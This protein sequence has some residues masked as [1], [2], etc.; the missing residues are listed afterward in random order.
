MSSSPYH[1]RQ[2]LNQRKKLI[3]HSLDSKSLAAD[4]NPLSLECASLDSIRTDLSI[5]SKDVII[6][7]QWI[8]LGRIGEGSFGEVFEAEDID[9]GR[10]YA[11]K[12]EPIKMRNRQIKHE[13]IIYDVLAGGPGIPQCHWHGQHD[14]FDCIVMDL[15][16]PNVNQLKEFLKKLPI[17][18]VVDFGC[19]MVTIVEHIH[20]RGLV[21][22]DIK[23]DN[24]LFSS[25]CFLPEPEMIE[26]TD[27]HG[28][29]M[30][31]Y[32]YPTCEEIFQKW[33][34]SHPKLYLVDFGLTTWWKNPATEK[35]Y[36]ETKK[37]YRNR[38]GTA[39]YASLHV[40][41]GK[42]HARRDDI[43]SIG[44]LLLDLVLGTLPWTGIQARNSRAGWDKMKQIKEDTFMDDLCAGL[45]Q[46]LLKFIEYARKI[47]FAEEPNYELLRQ[48][49]QGSIQ[50]GPYSDIIK[51]PFGGH[52]ESK[53]MQENDKS[54]VID[55]QRIT[56]NLHRQQEQQQYRYSP[57][58]QH[59]HRKPSYSHR[60]YNEDPGVFQMDDLAQAVND[61]KPN[62]PA[63]KRFSN[64]YRRTSRDFGKT[65]ETGYKFGTRSRKKPKQV[66]WNTH[67]HDNEPW[68]PT[69]DWTAPSEK[70][71]NNEKRVSWG[72]NN[73][74]AACDNK[75]QM[76][77]GNDQ[78]EEEGSWAATVNKPWE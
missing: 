38:A 10:K 13:N 56:N 35:P 37:D 52:T 64:S 59:R 15:L 34:V 55:K 72:E 71:E 69:I 50:G 53:W 1:I 54:V 73:P 28:M 40:H 43:E 68:A 3:S 77:W 21:Y 19:Q 25:Q 16:G 31:K 63:Q 14:E 46:G 17:E 60:G 11:V 76:N 36:P 30:I 29:S 26:S 24:F 62:T 57:Q 6:A 18:V 32:R 70:V 20:K 9:T 27:D 5:G 48:L 51:S 2:P 78:I 45:P 74:A 33:N 41:R 47:K 75:D 61:I 58:Q 12:R 65:C 44:Y 23:P 49:L 42:P 39:R 22:R 8:V 66:G 7:D 67:R 4:T